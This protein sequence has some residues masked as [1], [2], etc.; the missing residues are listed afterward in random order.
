MKQK[1]NQSIAR[2]V[3][4]FY[5]L[6]ENGKKIT[7]IDDDRE[8]DPNGDHIAFIIDI[9]PIFTPRRTILRKNKWNAAFSVSL[10]SF[11]R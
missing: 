11:G 5:F 9:S 8:N 7:E 6:P 4:T 3:R 1:R 10:P 2:K